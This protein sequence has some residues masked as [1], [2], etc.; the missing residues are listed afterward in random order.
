M[1]RF[2]EF[3]RDHWLAIT[4]L[5]VFVSCT[6]VRGQSTVPITLSFTGS[7]SG[8]VKG[9]SLSGSGMVAPYGAATVAIS[10]AGTNLVV[11]LQFSFSLA[12]G[13]TFT[14]SSQSTPMAGGFS[15]TATLS[16]GTGA[17]RNASGSFSFSIV[18]TAG[19]GGV[20]VSFTLTGSGSVG[21]TS[22]GTGPTFP[23]SCIGG[24][25]GSGTSVCTV[26][27]C[28][29]GSTGGSSVLTF[30]AAGNSCGTLTFDGSGGTGQGVLTFE[31]SGSGGSVLTFDGGGAGGAVLTVRRRQRRPNVRWRR[32]PGR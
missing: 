31:G 1:N 23:V 20:V 3:R 14:A 13:D 24:A 22:G 9:L 25:A 32:L 15:G 4:T 6:A 19:A 5:A 11:P 29:D 8:N 7:G 28:F 12:N 18:G 17:L 16:G 27:L 26:V 21:G 10:G 2:L 30:S